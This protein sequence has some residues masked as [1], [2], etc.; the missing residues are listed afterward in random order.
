MH[1]YGDV[2]DVNDSDSSSSEELTPEIH[3]S[4]G[5]NLIHLPK[6][7]KS[8]CICSY[9]VSKECWFAACSEEKVIRTPAIAGHVIQEI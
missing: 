8:S 3:S 5:D 9:F 2:S 4:K 7:V 1:N 6:N